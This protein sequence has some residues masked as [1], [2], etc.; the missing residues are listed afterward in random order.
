MH[1][2][3][4]L[5]RLPGARCCSSATGWATGSAAATGSVSAPDSS[6][7]MGILEKISEIEKEIARTQKNKGEG[8]SSGAFLLPASVFASVKWG[9]NSSCRMRARRLR[10]SAGEVTAPLT[11]PEAGRVRRD[12]GPTPGPDCRRP[13][14]YLIS[15]RPG[16]PVEKPQV[17]AGI[18]PRERPGLNPGLL[19]VPRSP[20]GDLSQ[21]QPHPAAQ[22]P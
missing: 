19:R 14:R 13:L 1:E 16:D 11:A 10:G 20:G 9:N 12:S 15:A 8:R 18:Q 7:S 6:V 3:A 17:T 5:R 2:D 22:S 21:V 4:V